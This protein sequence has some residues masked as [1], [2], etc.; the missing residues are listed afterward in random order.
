VNISKRYKL[1]DFKTTGFE[2]VKLTRV[3]SKW[4][5]QGG[6]ES[7]SADNMAVSAMLN[8]FAR[9]KPE[10][11]AATTK[12]KW[13][14]YEV[15][16]SLGNRVKVFQGD[17][18]T[19]DFV[20]GKFSYQQ[21]KNQYE[22]QGKMTSYV[23]L[24]DETEV[25]ATEGFLNMTFNRSTNDLRNK[26]VI[27]SD[28]N[29]WT[30]LTFNYP[31]DS[32]FVLIKENNNWMINGL[33]ADSN[34]VKSYLGSIARLNS[35]NVLETNVPSGQP[36]L[37]LSIEGNNISP[38]R[39]DAYQADTI[40]KYIIESTANPATPFSGTGSDL[41]TKLFVSPSRFMTGGEDVN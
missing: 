13:E 10:R 28:E 36:E 12:E 32:S 1:I 2:E 21:L 11:V 33:L 34:E 15:N 38:I 41:A 5:V 20:V 3:G 9:I 4:E 40:N 16:D 27:N 8:D 31:A 19:A 35:Q 18:M 29:S 22:R 23:R 7:F 17:E 30:R 26:T 14:H 24:F 39:I 25:Y 37:T 6:G